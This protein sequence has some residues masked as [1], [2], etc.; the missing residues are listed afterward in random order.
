MHI[1]PLSIKEAETFLR[2]HG[3]HYKTSATPVCAIGVK[4]AVLH[5]AAIFGCHKN[6]DAELSHIYCDG[7]STGYTLLYGASWRVLKAM[8][9]TKTWL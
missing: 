3:R 9:Y 6:G 7:V 4:N 8:G 1:V 5:G 2:K